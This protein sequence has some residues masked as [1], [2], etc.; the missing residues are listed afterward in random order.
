MIRGH[1][2]RADDTSQPCA[3][4]ACG[5]PQGEHVESVGEW[6]D[7]RHWYRP[8]LRRLSRCAR[9]ARPF[10]HSTHHGSRKNWR[11]WHRDNLRA[12]L[13]RLT[14]KERS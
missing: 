1:W 7:P 14:R 2:Y 13:D 4:E 5:R 6:M 12:R 10:A 11:M 3:Y 8:A 9:C